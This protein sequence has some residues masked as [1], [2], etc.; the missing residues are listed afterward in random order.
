MESNFWTTKACESESILWWLNLDSRVF[1]DESYIL[2]FLKKKN[3]KTTGTFK[4]KTELAFYYTKLDGCNNILNSQIMTQK[5]DKKNT[6]KTQ[7][8]HQLTKC[9]YKNDRKPPHLHCQTSGR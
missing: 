3:K 1:F 7:Q 9:K 5:G 2:E 6:K 8:N 4:Y